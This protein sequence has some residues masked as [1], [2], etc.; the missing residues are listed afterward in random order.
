MCSSSRL[1]LT[2]FLS[3]L[4][5]TATD[6][7]SE[8][9][10]RD[11]GRVMEQHDGY[12]DGCGAIIYYVAIGE[13][14]PL[15]LLHGGPG[16]SHTEFLPYLLLL[17]RRH[18]LVFIDERGSGR[19][20]RLDRADLYTLHAMAC[21]VDA[22]RYALG[23]RAIDVLG[24]SFGG[25]L[26]QAYA[27]EYPSAVRRLIVSSSGSSAA[28]INDDFNNI[29]SSLDPSLRAQIDALEKKGITGPDGAQSPEYRQL[30]DRAELPY[31][32]IGRPPA[33]DSTSEP[34][35]WDVLNAMWGGRSDFHIDGNMSGFDLVPALR[36]LRIPALV[37]L[38]DH[39][40]VSATTAAETRDAIVGA[41]L[42]VIPQSGH[43]TYVDQNATFVSAVG[44]FLEQ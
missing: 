34:A 41:R 11:K 18:Q 4:V 8:A 25:I 17:A 37:I 43:M 5:A 39:D 32:Q 20:Q 27:T 35:G 24:H 13:G 2:A 10:A 23:L 14:P 26:A 44:D 30:A 7:N 19:S 38:G 33:W 12:V 6:D 16:A 3:L 29:K 21:D 40:L 1:L 31:M 36:H 42:V 9:A 15:V 28:R 22:V